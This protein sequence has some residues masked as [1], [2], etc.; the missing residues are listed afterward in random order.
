VRLPARLLPRSTVM[1]IRRGPGRGMKW[2]SGSATHGCWL[3]TY[4]LEKQKLFAQLVRPGMTVYDIGAQAGYYT[5]MTS[6]MVGDSGQV[7]AFE[8]SVREAH[9]LIE[10]VRIN[11]LHNVRI[12]QAAVGARA[13]LAGFS[14]DR[15]P[16]ENQLTYQND[17]LM[18][19]VVALDS[20]GLPPPDLIKLDIEG[21]E[22]DALV[23]MR[24]LLVQKRPVVFVALHGTEHATFCPKFLRG[25][26][27][28]IFDVGGNRILDDFP[29]DEIYALHASRGER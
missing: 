20:A 11:R 17:G 10:H 26:G 15:A 13:G 1:H 28:S 19:P 24:G 2:I 18:V 12:V 4:E 5:L 7:F 29:V 25:C 14:T 27:Y 3:G 22:S 6:R 16:C 9:Y 21:G 23:G 8:P